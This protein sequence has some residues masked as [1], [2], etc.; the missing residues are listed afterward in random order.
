MIYIEDNIEL[1]KS[2]VKKVSIGT[3]EILTIIYRPYRNKKP[4]VLNTDDNVEKVFDLKPYQFRFD[5]LE[6]AIEESK[7]ICYK[8]IN[9]LELHEKEI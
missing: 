9:Q 1:H 3:I 2:Y 7:K 8:I 5:T 6:E 4:Y